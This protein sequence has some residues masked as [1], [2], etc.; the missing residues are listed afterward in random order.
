MHE[1]YI[2]AIMHA[3]KP[4]IFPQCLLEAGARVDADTMD[5]AKRL[6]R[7][8]IYKLLFSYLDKKPHV[9]KS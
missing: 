2:F 6:G 8:H 5:V 7:N 3:Y 9:V 1:F 4:W